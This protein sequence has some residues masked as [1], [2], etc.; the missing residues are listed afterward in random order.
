LQFVEKPYPF[1]LIP[2][3]AHLIYIL[4]IFLKDSLSAIIKKEVFDEIGGFAPIRMAGDFE[5][6]HRLA[7][8]I[9]CCINA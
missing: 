9:R 5:M 3:E 6:W 4:G 1:V 8:K 2:K 7:Q